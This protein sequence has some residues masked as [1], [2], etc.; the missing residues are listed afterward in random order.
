MM[1]SILSTGLIFAGTAYSV[2]F[3][4]SRLS[5]GSGWLEYGIAAIIFLQMGAM[6]IVLGARK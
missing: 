2:A 5:D 6:L 4:V 3:H 1:Q